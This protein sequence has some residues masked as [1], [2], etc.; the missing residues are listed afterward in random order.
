MCHGELFGKVP[1]RASKVYDLYLSYSH[2]DDELVD[3]VRKHLHLP[4]QGRITKSHQL[5]LGG[6]SCWVRRLL[7]LRI[8]AEPCNDLLTHLSGTPTMLGFPVSDC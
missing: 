1:A 7:G 2:E 5:L 3:F 8:E 4:W 6:V